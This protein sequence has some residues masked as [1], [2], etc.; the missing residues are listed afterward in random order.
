MV[1]HE[2]DDQSVTSVSSRQTFL[3][4]TSIELERG[5]D[6]QNNFEAIQSVGNTISKNRCHTENEL[7]DQVSRLKAKLKNQKLL[8]KNLL[9][10]A[11]SNILDRELQNLDKIYDDFVAAASNLRELLSQE[12]KLEMSSMIDIEDASVFQTKMAVSKRMSVDT[13]G[14]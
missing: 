14:D 4:D 12:E 8:I 10:S 13:F 11:A 1:E 5:V 7:K 3:S 9:N 6:K 2:T